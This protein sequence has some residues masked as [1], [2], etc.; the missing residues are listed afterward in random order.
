MDE[1]DR[2]EEMGA[3]WK[4][5]TGPSEGFA[6]RSGELEFKLMSMLD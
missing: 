6:D 1:M 5:V 2:K 4:G 3:G